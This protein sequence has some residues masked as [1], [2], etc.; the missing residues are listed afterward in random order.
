MVDVVAAAMSEPQRMSQL[1][2]ERAGLIADRADGVIRSAG[3]H[4][5]DLVVVAGRG[6]VAGAVRPAEDAL[7]DDDVIAH[8][9]RIEHAVRP[10]VDAD[11]APR[12]ERDDQVL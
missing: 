3:A 6:A 8:S 12:A 10:E 11:A 9:S 4:R 2:H 7:I 1:V 5:D